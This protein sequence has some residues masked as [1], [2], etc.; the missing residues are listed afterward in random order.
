MSELTDEDVFGSAAPA[1]QT[2]ELTDED[3]FGAPQKKFGD[4]AYDRFKL[5]ES[6]SSNLPSYP[7]TVPPSM[8]PD[9]DFTRATK[10]SPVLALAGQAVS[11]IDKHIIGPAAAT[12]MTQLKRSTAPETAIM[13]PGAHFPGERESDYSPITPEQKLIQLPHLTPKELEGATET[14]RIAYA[15]SNPLAETAEGL[16]TPGNI[17]LLPFAEAKP[18]QAFFAAGAAAG[19]PE[20]FQKLSEAKTPEEIVGA[21][22][23]LGINLGMAGTLIH[24]LGKEGAPNA[25]QVQTPAAIHGDVQSQSIDIES[26]VSPAKSGGGVQS[27]P[28]AAQAQVPLR[29]KEHYDLLAEHWDDDKHEFKKLS[30]GRVMQANY[31]TGKTE[32]DPDQFVQWVDKDLK[33]LNPKQKAAAVKSAFEH[34]DIHLKTDPEDAEPYWN[35]LS[36][37]EQNVLKRQYLKGGA[38]E[39][40]RNLGLEAI[41]NRVERAM[42]L[43]RNDFIG[44]ALRERWTAKSLDALANIVGKIRR[45]GDKELSAHQTAILDK[46]LS[47][48]DAAKNATVA[49]SGQPDDEESKYVEGPFMR[50]TA[51]PEPEKEGTVRLYRGHDGGNGGVYWSQDKT[52]ASRMGEQM[53]YLD[54]PADKVSDYSVK[55]TEGSGTPNAFKLPPEL[56]KEAKPLASEGVPTHN[57]D[58]IE[59]PLPPT[60][61]GERVVI[62][63]RPDGSLYRAAY[64][65][66]QYDVSAGGKAMIEK[67]GGSKVDS[68][69]TVNERGQ[70]T[71]GLLPKGDK[72]I[73]G[74]SPYAAVERSGEPEG[75]AMRRK[76]G[77]DLSQEK[78]FGEPITSKGV[79]GQESVPEEKP[80]AEA[81]GA[82]EFAEEQTIFPHQ[83][84]FTQKSSDTPHEMPF[85]PITDSESKNPA[86]LSKFLTSEGRIGG[87]DLPVSASRRMTVLFDKT[88]GK[89]HVVS[90]YRGDG[91]ARMVDPSISGKNRP[92]KP[93]GELL[94]RYKP[95]YSILLGEPR[96]NYHQQFNSLA[97]FYT[98][99]GEEAKLMARQFGTG[100][101]GIPQSPVRATGVRDPDFRGMAQEPAE[102]F[103]YPSEHE[104]NL[105]RPEAPELRALHDFFGDE[106]PSDRR[107]FETKLVRGAANASNQMISGLSKMMDIEK[108]QTRGLNDRQAMENV[109]D[110]LYENLQNSD[111]RSDFIE[112]TLAQS[113][114]HDLETDQ[115]IQER[116][117]EIRTA[118]KSGAR[119]LSTARDV[120]PTTVRG[121]HGPFPE[122]PEPKLSE[123]K[124]PEK[125]SAED[126]AALDAEIRKHVPPSA[127]PTLRRQLVERQVPQEPY[128]I[129]KSR[130]V[131]KVEYVDPETGETYEQPYRPNEATQ[132]DLEAQDE[133]ENKRQLEVFPEREMRSEK[134]EKPAPKESLAQ[135]KKVVAKAEGSKG[136]LDFW[137]QQ[138][139]AMRRKAAQVKEKVDDY[140]KRTAA[141]VSTAGDL[142]D[143]LYRLKSGE[144]ADYDLALPVIKASLQSIPAEDR[145]AL[146]HYADEMQVMGKSNIKLT[147][148][149]HAMY[150]TFLEP[151][152]HDNQK[153]YSDLQK[154]GVPVGDSTY[155][156]RIVQDTHSLY[157]R[158]ARGVKQRV[159]EGSVLGQ[160]ASFFKRRVFK[161][162]QDAEGNRRLV[163]LVGTGERTKVIAYENGKAE[164]LGNMPPKSLEVKP[165][166]E[167]QK[168]T[169]RIVEARRL[170]E[171]DAL[172]KVEN[173]LESKK[174]QLSATPEAAAQNAAQIKAID[175]KLNDLNQE[176]V[177]VNDAY[178]S[179]VFEQPRF[180]TDKAGN[181]W[182]VTDATVGEIEKNTNTRYYKEPMSGII[183]QNLKLKQ[184]SRANNFLTQLKDSSDF[185]RVSRSVNERNV[186]EDWRTVD[187]PQFRGLRIEPRTADVLDQFA[188]EQ[189]GPSLP[190]KYVSH[191]TSFLRN[192]LFTWNPF[193]HEPNLL[194]HWFTARGAEWA[195]PGGYDRMFKSG[196]EAM[197]DVMTRSRFRDQAL[198]AGAP[199]MRGMGK[200]NAEVM[201]LLKKE[202]DTTPTV[203]GKLARGLGYINPLRM[204]RAFGDSLTWGTNEILTLQLIRETMRR[205]G[206][207]L[208]D[209]IT[210]VGK[211]MPNY[212]VPPRVL[213]SRLISHV[214]QNPML[215]LWGHYHY[216]ALRS[217]GEMAK[218]ILSP[219]STM[220]ERVD[221][222]GRVATIGF[223]MAVMYPA[224]D[225]V[226][227]EIMKSKGYKMRRAGS[228]T[229][230]Q[231]ILDVARGKKTPEAALQS[232]VTPSPVPIAAAELLF[233]RNLRTGLPV[234]DRSLGKDTA[235][236]LGSFAASQVSPIQEGGNV[237]GGKKSLKE[238]GLGLAGISHTRADSAMAKFGRLADHWMQNSPDPAMREQYKR[239]TSEVF[240]ESDYQMLRSAII[241]GDQRGGQMAVEKL[242]KTRKPRDVA[243]RIEAWKDSPFTGTKKGDE[244]MMKEMTPEQWDLWYQAA[245]ERMDIANG[246]MMNLAQKVSEEPTK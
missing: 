98:Q 201:N 238:F 145:P 180:W 67:Y 1:T 151:L 107:M 239:R 166:T 13:G 36:S 167:V 202:L 125:L 220:R 143:Q 129:G 62:V 221:G 105:P 64:S 100:T 73:K 6:K 31:E 118:K 101:Q 134:P 230:P 196:V 37:F 90:T 214:M 210:E 76:K 11:A 130:P 63:K 74:F 28:E 156:G 89:V 149:Q 199:L 22:S 148:A 190:M 14:E 223:L 17:A 146:L 72:I 174:R 99:F 155:L 94:H 208:E 65:G 106:L 229:A 170:Q 186:P 171:L 157:S 24:S 78:L 29:T 147:D 59:S 25:S 159:T 112:R 175:G 193:V 185:K 113:R 3:V 41:R 82:R 8:N 228:A 215:S 177:R 197:N 154:A 163:A 161:A 216:G 79:P 244:A 45:L 85:R 162:V 66:K 9:W 84:D 117:A 188:A 128:T 60:A 48:I 158:L 103:Q 219:S 57:I 95:I 12:L 189:K 181:Q 179:P 39:T 231:N 209:A 122:A 191:L 30:D 58:D 144:K 152:L 27:S 108:R 139:P 246:M 53:E 20:S 137:K 135:E 50:R 184:I 26:E 70:W 47:N 195:K 120:A 61:P 160:S 33:G 35:S 235:K 237:L 114:T 38:D 56:T 194:A 142:S 111:T 226:I 205:T 97:D 173:Q 192:A 121:V 127:S 198:R 132:A 187:L 10:G 206:L 110:K 233:N 240:P 87:S 212:R 222:L 96:Q 40:P 224:I 176:Y 7:I 133:A 217:Y 69:G 183:T 16:S 126:Q 5:E 136:Q 80:S 91:V 172:G 23:R 88:N 102:N 42:G 140:L 232:I 18:V 225:S 2:K 109:L 234:Y 124:A 243:T 213:N 123:P 211:H 51:E 164:L 150:E 93:I 34:E 241:R 86:E 227:N 19:I 46:V 49:L 44:M 131:T 52:Y 32:I 218:E 236:D 207:P 104:P 178:P 81:S 115:A 54:V 92:N 43:E 55:K 204:V 165:L 15:A 21:G 138:P 153:M 116:L 4:D 242:L 200:M 169:Q 141:N 203:A 75:P 119:E 77:E 71:H 68:I 83:I 245:Q 168:R 182:E